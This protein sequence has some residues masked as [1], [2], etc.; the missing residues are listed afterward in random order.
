MAAD[1]GYLE[2]FRRYSRSN[3]EVVQ[4]WPKFCRFIPPKF[5]GGRAPGIFGVNLYNSATCRPCGKVSGRSVEGSRRKRGEKK[6]FGAK[7]K[8]FRELTFRAAKKETSAVKHKPGRPNN[9]LAFFQAMNIL[10]INQSVIDMCASFFSLLLTVMDTK[11][12]DMSHDSAYDQFMC[13]FWL[14]KKPQWCMLVTSTYG[15]VILTLSR[16]IAVIYPIQYR[17][18][19]VIMI[20]RLMLCVFTWNRRNWKESQ[21]WVYTKSDDVYYADNILP[22]TFIL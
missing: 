13:R 19:R 15:T 5:F 7:Y 3:S 21:S 16:Y 11:M 9:K 1:F 8:P 2:P 4:N 14:T 18:V 10:I 6:T 20:T 22:R 12:T 17:I